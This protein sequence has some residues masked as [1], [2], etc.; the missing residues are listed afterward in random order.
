MAI[1]H[2]PL[3]VIFIDCINNIMRI[4][5]LTHNSHLSE[6]VLKDLHQLALKKIID[7]A[8]PLKKRQEIERKVTAM[9]QDELIQVKRGVENSD[10][11][12]ADLSFRNLFMYELA[13]KRLRA[14]NLSESKKKETKYVYRIDSKKITNFGKKLNKYRH[15]PNWKISQI[16]SKNNDNWWNKQ[17]L[18]YETSQGLFAGSLKYVAPYAT[19]NAGQ[20][21]FITYQNNGKDYV[22][23]D[24]RQREEY[25]NRQTYLSVFDAKDFQKTASNEYFSANPGKPIEQI[26]INDPF[27]FIRKQGL[28]I[29]FV[30]NINEFFENYKDKSRFTGWEGL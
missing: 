11:D 9:T 19:G 5:D 13:I 8:L 18:N 16:K 28:R 24:Q 3:C 21:C 1:Q 2:F 20:T 25:K 6:G 27:E 10:L 14:Q 4:N 15:T 7:W 12:P 26:P 17:D 29:K 30:P 23:F 22:V